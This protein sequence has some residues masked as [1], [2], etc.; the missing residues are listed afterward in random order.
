[1]TIFHWL[2]TAFLLVPLSEIYVLLQVGGAIGAFPTIF[3]VV[4]TAVVG[5]V[6]MLAQGFA[7]VQKVQ[8]QLAAGEIPAVAMLEGAFILVA[9]ALLLTPGFIT[10]FVGFCCLLP[11]LRQALIRRM[12]FRFGPRNTTTRTTRGHTIDADFTRHEDDGRK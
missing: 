9:G 8:H 10:D 6:L 5:A 11:P 3:L 1:M 2:L 12:S 4:F 7:T